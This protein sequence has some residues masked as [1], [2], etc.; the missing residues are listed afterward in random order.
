MQSATCRDGVSFDAGNLDVSFHG[1]TG[2]AKVVFHPHFGSVFNL[3]NCP[4]KKLG[5]R[6]R[7]HGTGGA[8]FSLTPH[9]SAGNGRILLYQVSD[10]PGSCKCTENSFGIKVIDF[11]EIVQ[12]G[13]Q[14]SGG[15]AGGS[16]YD[17]A[18]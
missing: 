9:F 11:P 8:D 10:K 4:A 12:N 17:D 5:G 3:G 15:S 13:G 6:S 1:V 14:N 16:C 18:T 7:C 2:E